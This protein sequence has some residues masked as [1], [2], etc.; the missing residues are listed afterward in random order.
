MLPLIDVAFEAR[1][2]VANANVCLIRHPQLRG[3][4]YQAANVL[5]GRA[6]GASEVAHDYSPTLS[7]TGVSPSGAAGAPWVRSAR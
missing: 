5:I 7:Y 4:A 6:P 3:P 2:A 1:D